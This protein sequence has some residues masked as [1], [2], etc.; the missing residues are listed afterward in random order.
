M[1]FLNYHH[2]RYFWAIATE[3]SLTRAAQRLNVAA[4]SLSVQLKAL[5]AQLGQDLFDRRGRS[6]Q[7]TEAGRIALDHANTVFQAG[8]ELL[9]TLKGLSHDRRQR[10]RIGAVA[11]LSRNFQIGL[12]RP[13][14]ER[15]D[16][17]LSLRS[18][19]FGELLD[20]LAAHRLDLVLANQPAMI[21]TDSDWQNSLI[22]DQP[23]SLVGRATKRARKFVFPDDLGQVPIVLPA[24]GSSI[25]MTFD[26]ILEGSGITPIISAEVD[27]MAMLRLMARESTGVT[28][29]P[30]V[31]VI[32]EL[33]QGVLVERCRLPQIRES[34]YAITRRRRFPNPL[35]SDVLAK[36]GADLGKQT[37]DERV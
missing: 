6:L 1:S 36:A 18:G 31:V 19:T 28:L 20:H 17:E 11:T 2:L 32:D 3:G 8:E 7:L 33:T 34:F 9:A 4:S 21:E 25:R 16:V 15:A 24:Q 26:R 30:P 13:L 10:L 37:F 35:L 12:L 14:I 5:E 22:A 27:D 23:V 29:V